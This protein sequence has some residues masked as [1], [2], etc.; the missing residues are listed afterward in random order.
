MREASILLP[1]LTVKFSICKNRKTS[2][3]SGMLPYGHEDHLWTGQTTV[4]KQKRWQRQ[5]AGHWQTQLLL[6]A[7]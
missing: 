4:M 7:A 1:T 5:S 2:I 3:L 6:P